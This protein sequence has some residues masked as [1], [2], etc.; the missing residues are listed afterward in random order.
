MARPIVLV[1]NY[2]PCS[3]WRD[4][5]KIRMGYPKSLT[6]VGADFIRLKGDRL[7]KPSNYL[8]QHTRRLYAG[9]YFASDAQLNSRSRCNLVAEF[10]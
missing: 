3:F 4:H 5:N 9:I 2:D 1:G 7:I 10:E 8:D 6:A